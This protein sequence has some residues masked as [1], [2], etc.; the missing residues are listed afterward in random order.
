MAPRET[1]AKKVVAA[2]ACAPKPEF[3]KRQLEVIPGE[4]KL[5]DEQTSWGIVQ[6]HPRLARSI[7]LRLRLNKLEGMTF[8]DAHQIVLLNLFDSA[9]RWDPNEM[10]FSDFAW[11]RAKSAYKELDKGALLNSHGT[12]RWTAKYWEW[13]NKNRAEPLESFAKEI[14]VGLVRA[15]TIETAALLHT[16]SN[17]NSLSSVTDAFYTDAEEPGHSTSFSR[18]SEETKK[19]MSPDYELDAEEIKFAKALWVCIS[20]LPKKNKEAVCRYFC[21][22]GSREPLTFSELAKEFGV[23]QGCIV[24]R[25]HRG[26]SNMREQLSALKLIEMD[27]EV[28]ASRLSD[29]LTFIISN[30]EGKKEWEAE[31]P[32]PPKKKVQRKRGL[33]HK[34]PTNRKRRESFRSVEEAIALAEKNSH[35]ISITFET[36]GL[37]KTLLLEL[38]IEHLNQES[39][40][41]H[42]VPEWA[43]RIAFFNLYRSAL[44]WDGNG[45]FELYALENLMQAVHQI[46]YTAL[47]DEFECKR[48]RGA[49]H[50]RQQDTCLYPEPKDIERALAHARINA[51]TYYYSTD[52]IPTDPEQLLLEKE[53]QRHLQILNFAI[54]D[55]SLKQAQS[56][57]MAYGMRDKKGEYLDEHT[58][59]EIG[60]MRK[61]SKQAIKHQLNSAFETLSSHP[62]L[63]VLRREGH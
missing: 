32:A 53:K 28:S 42:K 2:P 25:V 40:H 44:Y 12:K 35:L 18:L 52:G 10:P 7:V 63:K 14:G 5:R 22:E 33:S 61:T 8:E 57:R 46:R 59:V 9:R 6:K 49:H 31:F 27:E 19:E 34:Y 30:R 26:I 48:E 43:E 41:V 58:Y 3:S 38:E 21:I 15:K 24:S 39:E 17:N 60:T 50:F 13:R 11:G 54:L 29:A 47:P 45:D 62:I 51:E 55:L 20:R 16:T 56:I 36:Y 1:G 4:A 23:T 37:A